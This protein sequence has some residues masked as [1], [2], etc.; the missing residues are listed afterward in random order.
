M[1]GALY[2][3]GIPKDKLF[4]EAERFFGNKGVTETTFYL[5]KQFAL[6]ID[7]RSTSDKNLFGNGK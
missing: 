5:G 3:Q 1:A 6:V 2:N 4:V 7:L